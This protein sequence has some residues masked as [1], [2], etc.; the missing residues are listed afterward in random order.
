MTMQLPEVDEILSLNLKA[1]IMGCR[2]IG[3]HMLRTKTQGSIINVSSLLA[4]KG[5]TGTSVYA[6]S[7]AGIL[8]ERVRLRQLCRACLSCSC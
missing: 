7:K 3:R 8:G 1:T 5:I 2:E 6:A 4:F